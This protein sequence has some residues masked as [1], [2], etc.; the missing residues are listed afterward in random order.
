MG[1][2]YG[3]LKQLDP[4]GPNG[5][6]L[7]DYSVF[8]AIRAGFERVVFVI[9]KDFEEQFR[10]DVGSR[11]ENQVEV[12][13]AFQDLRM[14]PG[15]YELPEGREKPWGTGHAIWCAREVLD[16]P[17]VSINADDF[18]GY[19]SFKIMAEFLRT[20]G[21]RDFSMAGYRL[22]KTLS[23]HGSVS[24]G[25]CVVDE[26]G[27]LKSVEELTQ[28]EPAPEGGARYVKPDG[29]YT[30]LTGAEPVSMNFWGLTPEVFALLETGFAHFLEKNLNVPKSEYYIPT[31]IAEMIESDAAR[32]KVLPTNATWFGV[33]YREDKP[34]VMASLAELVKTGEYPTPLWQSAE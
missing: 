12:G 26:N 21:P 14:L 25:V 8:D 31:A 19:D 23:D 27:Y 28:I 15:G 33:T 17:F 7:L 18:Y 30:P 22:D 4:M 16:G 34:L 5:E 3:G 11:F 6:T 24:R 20:A 1:S 29:G 32:V 10:R 13:Y 9:R 2:R